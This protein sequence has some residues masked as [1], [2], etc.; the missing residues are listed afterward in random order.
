[1]RE[2]VSMTVTVPLDP[3]E[4]ARLLAV[5]RAKGLSTSALVREPLDRI[6][7]EAP[8]PGGRAGTNLLFAWA[9]F[10]VR[11]GFFRRANRSEP[12]GDVGQLS[13]F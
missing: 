4:E 1:M 6:P 2:V 7:A 13:A 11:A 5:A 9:P 12:E 10:A 3:Q 8:E